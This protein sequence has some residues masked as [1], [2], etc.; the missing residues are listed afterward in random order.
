MSPSGSGW[1]SKV[2]RTGMPITT[3]GGLLFHRDLAR[4]ADET[5]LQHLVETYAGNATPYQRKL[6]GDSLRAALTLEE[7]RNL[8]AS[9]GFLRNP[10]DM[11]SDRHWTWFANT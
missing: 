11:T 3:H 5:E 8:V 9:L 2:A 6:F 4:P 1:C 10:V 7:V